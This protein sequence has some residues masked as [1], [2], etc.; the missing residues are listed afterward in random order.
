MTEEEPGIPMRTAEMK[1][2]ETPPIQIARSSTKDVVEERPKVIGRSR[3][4][5]RVAESPGIAPK[6]IPKDTMAMMR[7]RFTGLRQTRMAFK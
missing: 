5:P 3:A 2:P 7:I 1:V 4:I 6:T